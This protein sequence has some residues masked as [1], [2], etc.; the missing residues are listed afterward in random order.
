MAEGQDT[1]QDGRLHKDAAADSYAGHKF[2]TSNFSLPAI[3]FTRHRMSG[4]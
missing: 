1:T 4:C 3:P 2:A